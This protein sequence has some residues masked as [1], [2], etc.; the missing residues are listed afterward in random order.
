MDA[1]LVR[2]GTPLRGH[3]EI[4]GAKNAALPILAACL[5]AEGTHA[6]ENVPRLRD[7]ATMSRLLE[8]L[9][10]RV[11]GE[12]GALRVETTAAG[13]REAPYEL[14]KTMRASIYVLGPLLARTGRARVSLPGGCAWG[15]R[16]VDLHIDGLVRM[17]ATIDIDHGYIDARADRLR[18]AAITFPQPSVGAT[19]HL[20]M[21]AALAEGETVI[22]NAAMEPEIPALAEF[23]NTM[24][25]RVTGA[26]TARVA[27]E[28]VERLAPGRTRVVP[29]RI[30]MGTYAAA[31][32]ITGGDVTLSGRVSRC[33]GAVLDTLVEAGVEIVEEGEATRVRVPRPIRS[34]DVSTAPYPG[35][36]TDMQAQMMALM[37]IADGRSVITDTIYPDRFTHVAELRRL[38]ADIEMRGNSAIVSHVDGL[39]GAPVMATDLRASA[40]LVLAGLVARGETRVSRVYHIDR[41]YE[42]IERKL[43]ALGADIERIRE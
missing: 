38:G 29:D 21:A 22:A 41:G 37:T 8:I 4:G 17:G 13:G 12:S 5:L 6:I 16:P 32:A 42:A 34:V 18:G 10:A 33:F 35:F 31:G 1:I 25:A 43:R 23:L 27:I 9:G 3:V 20:M 40:A 36:A 26:G 7:V 14:V 2:G 30:E 19:A 39:S 15:P 24:G 28:G 11:S